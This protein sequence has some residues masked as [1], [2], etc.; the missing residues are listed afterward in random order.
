[1]TM[2]TY[3]CPSCSKMMATG[4]VTAGRG[5]RWRTDGGFHLT[6]FGGE[7]VVSM[8]R[9]SGTPAARC[10]PCALVLIDSKA[11]GA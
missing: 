11:G 8:W 7:P 3:K 10:V 6:V 1:M 2:A 4:F 9:S 5:I